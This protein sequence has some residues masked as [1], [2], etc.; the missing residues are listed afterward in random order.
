MYNQMI[1]RTD[2]CND[3]D[4]CRGRGESGRPRTWAQ[5][6]GRLRS[7]TQGKFCTREGTK[8]GQKEGGENMGHKRAVTSCCCKP[9]R[10]GSKEMWWPLLCYSWPDS[11]T[12]FH[13]KNI[14]WIQIR[15]TRG[16]SGCFSSRRGQWG[17]SR[18]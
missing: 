13:R 14:T 3:L 5:R 9:T 18:R 11:L 7:P 10:R 6:S 8:Q 4:E 15:Q 17:S 2:E 16:I 12:N 1:G